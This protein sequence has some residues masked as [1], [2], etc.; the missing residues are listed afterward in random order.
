MSL[1]TF[2]IYS[3]CT[4]RGCYCHASTR[5]RMSLIVQADGT[6]PLFASPRWSMRLCRASGIFVSG[7]REGIFPSSTVLMRVCLR[8]SLPLALQLSYPAPDHAGSQASGDELV[9]AVHG[10]DA[11]GAGCRTDECRRVQTRPLSNH[12]Y[13]PRLWRSLN[14]SIF[15][16]H[17]DFPATSF[18]PLPF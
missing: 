15:P 2:P 8:P 3:R 18:L 1:R 17:R 14:Q 9:W 11:T 12:V 16:N 5:Q 10:L 7:V 6:H 4:P 13:A